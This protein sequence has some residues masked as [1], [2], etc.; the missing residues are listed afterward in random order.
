MR[1]AIVDAMSTSRYL[2]GELRRH[3]IECVHVSS[4]FPDLHMEPALSE[5]V[6]CLG[7]DGGVEETAARLRR[8]D[9]GFVVAGTESGVEFADLL[10]AALGTPANGMERRLARR[11]KHEMVLALSDAGV[12]H[13]ATIVSRDVGEIVAW[14]EAEPGWPIVLKP[15]ASAGTDHVVCCSSPKEVRAA[16]ETI[17]TATDR[18]GLPNAAVLAQEFLEGAEYFVNTVS[19]DGSHRTA[20]VWRYHKR[21]VRGGYVIFDH[22]EPID[23]DDP[24][25]GRVEQYTR[26]VL[27]ALEIRNAAGHSEVML[28]RRGPILVECGARLGGGQVPEINMR[29]LGMSQMHLQALAIAKP[30]EF[31]RLPEVAYAL[32]ERPRHVSLI[33]PLEEG[34][35]P[36]DEALAAIHALPSYAHTV[37]AHPA[38]SPIPRTIDVA[39][40]PGFVY[41]ISDDREQIL[42]DY[43]T[44]REI[45]EDYLYDPGRVPATA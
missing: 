42:A 41:L 6:E 4:P 37:M 32:R 43:R 31:E 28:T 18:F 10:S 45:E 30:V 1:V 26:R 8:L 9:V 36:G 3:G 39:T 44:L 22:H 5:F 2:P 34:V 19:R 11:N 15:V 21:R 35:V 14:A 7:S 25:G 13:A 27:D 23:P 40:Q 20:E 38:G 24:D 17:V 33:N 16:F 29:C 12:P